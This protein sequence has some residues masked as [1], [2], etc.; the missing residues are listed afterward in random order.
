MASTSPIL[1]AVGLAGFSGVANS[2]ISTYVPANALPPPAFGA[3]RF[4]ARTS[5]A[6][7]AAPNPAYEFTS[8]LGAARACAN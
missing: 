3:I 6:F 4:E 8:R 7:A 5:A 2:E 1:Q